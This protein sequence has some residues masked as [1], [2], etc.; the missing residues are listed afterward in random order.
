MLPPRPLRPLPPL[1]W[2]PPPLC[3]LQG[4]DVWRDGQR[5]ALW[6]LRMSAPCGTCRRQ[7]P[8]AF[9]RSC[10]FGPASPGVYGP[11][12]LSRS[13]KGCALLQIR[14][15]VARECLAP[16]PRPLCRRPRTAPRPA[17]CSDSERDSRSINDA[18]LQFKFIVPSA[19]VGAVLGRGGGT[20]AAIKRETG[21]YVQFTRPGTAT[22]SPKE[23][24]MIV[25]VERR[26]Q[27]PKAIE[28][29]FQVGAGR[30]AGPTG[31]ARA[32]AP[33]AAPALQ[34]LASLP[35]WQRA[36][37]TACTCAALAAAGSWRQLHACLGAAWKPPAPS[38]P[39]LLPSSLLCL[40]SAAGDG[41]RGR[42]GQAA[43]QAVCAGPLLLPAGGCQVGQRGGAG[44]AR[45][46]A[47]PAAGRAPGGPAAVGPGSTPG[48]SH[49]TELRTRPCRLGNS[50][51][52]STSWPWAPRRSSPPCAPAR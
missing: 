38:C 42:P 19:V 37:T 45:R 36:R 52:C 27:L 5:R 39:D 8:A 12:R 40:A 44:R 14:Y 29:V 32:R 22:N 50:H 2:P 6:Q 11:E 24:M 7:P 30:P 25:A 9:H 26:D 23:R 47:A 21:A 20:V 41:A 48:A 43:H 35:G 31:C 18:G 1:W 46:A 10:P 15:C 51:F 3:E 17:P 28:L 34:H 49:R 33:G 4:P 13:S 16:V